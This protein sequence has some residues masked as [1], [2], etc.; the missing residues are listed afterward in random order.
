MLQK[1]LYPHLQIVDG[2]AAGFN[3]GAGGNDIVTNKI[4]LPL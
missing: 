2:A 1:V 4:F 3:S